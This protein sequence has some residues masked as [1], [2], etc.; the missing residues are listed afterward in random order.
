M[1][2]S[3]IFT[4]IGAMGERWEMVRVRASVADRLRARLARLLRAYQAGH[5]GL[6]AQCPMT[7]GGVIEALLN[8]IDNDDRRK[9]K[10]RKC[11]AEARR[12]SRHHIITSQEIGL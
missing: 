6:Q 9:R 10:S 3:L 5:P 2:P 1:P 8:H 4:E 12:E 11:R 7:L